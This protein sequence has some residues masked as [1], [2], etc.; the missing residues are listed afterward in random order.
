[1]FL[2]VFSIHQKFIKIPYLF[3]PSYCCMIS[4]CGLL[5]NG[6]WQSIYLI[7]YLFLMTFL[8]LVNYCMQKNCHSFRR[9]NFFFQYRGYKWLL[10]ERAVE[11]SG[12]SFLYLELFNTSCWI[13]IVIC[14]FMATNNFGT[15]VANWFW[16]F[17]SNSFGVLL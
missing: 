12:F 17:C 4:V 3:E 1:M 11:A 8:I 6:K 14:Y 7:K 13:Y 16:T 15:C 5:C 2:I 9:D 10:L